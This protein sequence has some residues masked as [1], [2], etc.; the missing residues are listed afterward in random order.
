M[1]S[2]FVKTETHW[3]ESVI[4]YIDT[5]ESKFEIDNLSVQSYIVVLRRGI[6]LRRQRKE[7][8]GD[9]R[10]TILAKWTDRDRELKNNTS[11][12]Y[13]SFGEVVGPFKK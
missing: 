4:N 10:I 7:R 1:I 2:A 9:Q 8:G 12:D 5:V 11:L 6:Q 3:L 13:I